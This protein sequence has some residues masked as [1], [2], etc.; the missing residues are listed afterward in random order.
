L[1][2][3]GPRKSNNPSITLVQKTRQASPRTRLFANTDGNI[4]SVRRL[5]TAATWA[6]WFDEF[7]TDFES[8]ATE[9]RNALA[10]ERD[11]LDERD[12]KEVREKAVVLSGHPSFNSGRPSFEKRLFLADQLFPKLDDQK[13]QKITSR[14]EKLDWLQKSGFKP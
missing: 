9:A 14:A 8:A 11:L 10:N 13:L 7:E 2:F 1:H 6:P 12:S 3:H 5:H 4:A